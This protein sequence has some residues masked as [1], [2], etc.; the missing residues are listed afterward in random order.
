MRYDVPARRLPVGL[1][2]DRYLRRSDKGITMCD[3]RQDMLNIAMG[4]NLILH[5]LLQPLAR[6]SMYYHKQGL[7]QL[8]NDIVAEHVRRLAITHTGRG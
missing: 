4:N 7:Q 1:T 3:L 8:L 2:L 5:K 6:P